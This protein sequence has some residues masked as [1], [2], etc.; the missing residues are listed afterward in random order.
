VLAALIIP[1]G[2]AAAVERTVTVEAT[3]T[4]KVPN[5]TAT[6][7]FGV[8]AERKSRGA[9]LQAASARLASVIA[10]AQT[11]P[12]V[13]EGDVKTGR[14]N[15]NKAFRGRAPIYRAS[16][17]ASV[18]LHEPSR[19]G[20]LVQ[21]A[22][23]AGASG[24]NGPSYSVG[25]TEAATG[26]ALAAAFEKARAKA[27]VLATQAGA[28]LGAALSIKEGGNAEIV[29]VEED[30]SAAPIGACGKS[31]SSTG[32]GSAP[33]T[34][35]ASE[36]ACGTPPPTKPGNSTVTATVGVIFALG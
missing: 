28:S 21:V 32:A 8:S 2:A 17:G 35:R 6:V 31:V 3:A 19:A 13:G 20:E 26:T 25:D 9:A 7:G 5:D 22:I 36:S 11:V 34:K 16:E 14:V 18:T 30:K 10:K 1:A 23:A 27:A 4:I 29:P 15:V 24:V 12:G 33:A